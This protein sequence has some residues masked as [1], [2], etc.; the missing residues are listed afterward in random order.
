MVTHVKKTHSPAPANNDAT[1]RPRNPVGS[2]DDCF[3]AMQYH[4]ARARQPELVVPQ[5]A[6]DDRGSEPPPPAASTGP[7]DIIYG[8]RAIAEYVF[9]DGGNRAR[10][11]VFN[12]WA[13]YSVRKEKAGFFKLKGALCLSKSQ[14][15]SFHGLE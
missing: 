14:W 13:H 7:G 9:G 2:A 15:R 10:R 5:P 12:L 3:R 11:R 4:H 1:S 6:H 8:A